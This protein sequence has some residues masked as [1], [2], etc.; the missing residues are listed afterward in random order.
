LEL[1]PLPIS[2]AAPAARAYARHLAR[3]DKTLLNIPKMPQP[4]FSSART[5][6][7]KE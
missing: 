3:R 1:L 5:R 6:K 7:R 2:A 4:D